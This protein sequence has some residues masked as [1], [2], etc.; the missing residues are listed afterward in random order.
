MF[1]RH[2]QP[3]LPRRKFAVRLGLG[4]AA[5]FGIELLLMILGAAGYHLFE[6][7]SWLDALVNAAMVITGNGPLSPP[8]TL[9][10]KVFLIFD[11][12]LGALAFITV[13]GVIFAPIFHRLMHA[14]HIEVDGKR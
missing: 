10:G 11:A 6:G 14:F 2:G 5:G 4:V 8:H 1:E 9:G 7:L 3:L 13:A 12:L